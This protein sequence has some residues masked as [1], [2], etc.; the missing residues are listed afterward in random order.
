MTY[1][2]KYLFL[3]FAMKKFIFSMCLKLLVFSLCLLDFVSYFSSVQLL[4]RVRLCDPMDCST[5]GL[6]VC[7]QFPELAQTHVHWV[8]DAIQPSHPLSS[9]SPPAFSL[10]QHQGLF[11]W[12]SSSHLLAKLRKAFYTLRWKKKYF[13]PLVFANGYGF[14]FFSTYLKNLLN[15]CCIQYLLEYKE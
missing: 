8:G 7:H 12:V 6:P 3:F 1:C 9:P 11:Q 15:T 10:S 14:I 4:N 5:P 2:C 13:F